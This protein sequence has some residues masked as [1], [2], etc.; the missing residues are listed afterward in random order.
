MDTGSSQLRLGILAITAI[1]LFGA[2]FARLWYLQ[3]MVAPQYTGVATQ[4]RER[5]IYEEPPRGR[6][7]D[8][9]GAVL[10]DNRTSLVITANLQDPAILDS[11]RRR[12]LLVRVAGQLTRV[13]IPTKVTTLERR[14]NDRQFNPLTPIPIAIDIPE[15][16]DIYIKEHSEDFPGIDVAREQVRS[17]PKGPIAA[18]V[19]GYVGRVNEEELAA[20]V[21]TEADPKDNPKHYGPASTYGKAGVERV[22]EDDLRGVPGVRKVEV[23]SRGRVVRTVSYSPP[24]PGNDV[25]LAIDADLQEVAERAL[26]DQLGAVRGL[27]SSSGYRQAPAGSL[28]ITDPRDGGVL[29]MASYPTYDPTEFVNGISTERYEAIRTGKDSD[30]PLINRAIGGQYAPGSTFK[31][32][33][34]YA[35][36]HRGVIDG[37]FSFGDPGTYILKNCTGPTCRKQNAGGIAHGTVDLATAL[38]VSS[39]VFFYHLGDEFYWGH[40]KYGDGI[41][42]AARTFGFGRRTGIDIPGEAEGRVPDPAWKQELYDALPEEQKKNGSPTWQ[43]G[44]TVNLAIGQGDMLATP[45]QLAT[46]YS[47]FVHHGEVHQPRV[48]VRVLRPAGDPADPKALVRSFDPVIKGTVDLPNE[49]HD[50][51]RNGL[52]NVPEWRYNGTAGEA[53]RGFDTAAYPIIAKTGTAQANNKVDNALFTAC[54]PEPSEQL[55]VAIVLE[56][57]GFGGEAAA[58]IARR[59]FD[60]TSGQDKAPDYTPWKPGIAAELAD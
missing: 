52:V 24:E 16:L 11:G 5:T 30:N 32:V 20:K 50:P 3:V 6:I 23:D 9:T 18:H 17:Y 14:L 54:G 55:C 38:T 28:V 48:A 37:S 49:I 4:N 39:D 41:Q 15:E 2:L 27:Y 31:L 42:D 8:R 53:F 12:E 51:I 34:A 56:E 45:L 25:Q 57:A 58:P 1:S 26:I 10:V 21:G 7:L 59:I 60:H 29:A 46:A 44:D 22:Y 36:M 35:A 33:T 40:D 43:P 13:G 47:G 19:L